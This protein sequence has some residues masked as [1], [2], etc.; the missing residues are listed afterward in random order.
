[1]KKKIVFS[2]GG[3]GGHI[4]PAV[5]LMNHFSTKGYEVVLVTDD[6]GKNF[7]LNSSDF[8]S[9]ILKTSTPTNKSF[10]KKIVAYFMIIFSVIQSIIFLKKEKPNLVFGLGGYVSFPI[11]FASKILNF[12]MVIYENNMILG[13]ANKYLSMFAKKIFLAKKIIKNFPKKYHTKAYEVGVV[14]DKKVINFK[15]KIDKNNKKNFSILIIGGSQGAEIFG[16]IIPPVIKM[17]KVEGYE[18]EV[19]QQ[20]ILEQK[21][22]LEKFY[23][24]NNIKNYI[25]EFDKNILDLMSSA[26]LAITRCGA[27]STA[28]LVSTLTPFIGVPLPK[29][30][31]NHQYLNGEY[32]QN[33]GC[34]W[35]LEQDNFNEENLF[36]LIMETIKN[37]NK[38]ENARKCMKKNYKED[39]YADIEKEIKEFIQI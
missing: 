28:E 26:S 1:M 18:I 20:C 22:F 11:C 6:R 30:I 4:F 5:N 31:D 3:S 29:S 15:T 33:Q 21:N 14:L 19:M 13:R 24:N 2:A 23:N 10:L 38:L 27:S 9:Y 17:I 7:T 25:F 35:L 39:V 36:N 37:K 8:K 32:Y 12:P 34:C 16:K